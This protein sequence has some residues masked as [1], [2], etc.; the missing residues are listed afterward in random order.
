MQDRIFVIG[1]GIVIGALDLLRDHGC[2]VQSMDGRVHR[3]ELARAIAAF[4]P[5]GIIVRQGSITAEL[6]EMAPSLKAICKHGV[7]VD[8]IDVHA[9]T[10]RG[11]VVMFTPGAN[12]NAAAEHTLGLILALIRRIPREDRRVRAGIFDKSGYD[13]G[14]LT[15]KTLGL[16]GFGRIGRRVAA[17]VGPFDVRVVVY[18]PSRTQ[19]TLASHITKFGDLGEVLRQSDIVS[20]HCPLKPMTR[21]LINDGTIALMKHGALLINTARGEIVDEAALGRALLSKRLGGAGLDVFATEPPPVGHPF[22]SMDEVVLTAHVAGSSDNALRTM[23]LQ[24]ASNL[25]AAL[26]GQPNAGAL[27]NPD[28]LRSSPH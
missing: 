17:L 10:Q 7:G 2:A 27:I 12:A 1:S 11:I 19:E 26:K 4:D 6:M 9:A 22:L 8:S 25:L 15:G 18:H 20:L 14:E 13:G 3:S 16:I 24:A 28:V 23:G 5:H 21:G